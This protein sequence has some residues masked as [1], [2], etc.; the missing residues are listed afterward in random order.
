M[1]ALDLLDPAVPEAAASLGPTHL[2]PHISLYCNTSVSWVSSL[3]SKGPI[4]MPLSGALA[5]WSVW[6][7][8]KGSLGLGGGAGKA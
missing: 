4:R 5:V 1:T 2:K 3:A 6:V 8:E 7:V